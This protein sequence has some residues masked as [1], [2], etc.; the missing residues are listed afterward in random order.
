MAGDEIYDDSNTPHRSIG[1]FSGKLVTAQMWDKIGFKWVPY[2]RGKNAGIMSANAG[3]SEPRK[4]KRKNERAKFQAMCDEIYEQF[5]KHVTDCRGKKLAKPIEDLAGGRVYT[6]EQAAALG[7]VDR[8][9][10]LDAAIEAAAKRAKIERYDVRVIPEPLNP[11]EQFM[12]ELGGRRERPSDVSLGAQGDA[13]WPCSVGST[14]STPA[15]P[16]GCS[17]PSA[18]CATRKPCSSCR[19]RSSFVDR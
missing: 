6:G 1:V 7:L 12:A 3:F 11:I 9:G 15:P 5:K 14:P 13:V 17:T 10:G 2:R 8:L 16:A 4:K 18:C 19:R